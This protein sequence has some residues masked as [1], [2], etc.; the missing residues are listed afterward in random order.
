MTH[1]D[2]D[3]SQVLSETHDVFNQLHPLENQNLFTQDTALQEAV[4]RNGAAWA[5]EQ[6]SA[7]GLLTGSSKVIEWGFLA[8]KHK[9]SFKTHDRFGRR[10]DQV[11]FHPSYHHLM[12]QAIE[13]GLHASP[14]TDPKAGAHVARAA[15]TYMQSQVEAGHGCPI[16]MT[17]ACTPTFLKQPNVAKE[18]LPK[19]HASTYDPS[20]KPY[21]EKSGLTIGMGMT[22]KQ[23]GSDVRANTTRAIPVGQPGPGELY[24]LIGHKWFLSA[25]MCDGFLVLAQAEGGLSCFLVPRWQPDGTRNPMYVQQLK[26][27][28][29]NVSNASSEVE[30][31]GAIAWLIGEEGRGVANILEMVALTRFD[32]MVGSSAGMRQAVSQI[33]HHAQHRSVFGN[34]L[35]EQPLMQNVLADLALESEAAMSLSFRMAKALDNMANDEHEALLLRIGTAVGKYWICKR[36]PAHAYEAMECIGG[37]AVMEDCIMPRLYREAPINAIWE[38]SGNV[39][40]LDVLRAI[41]KSPKTLDALMSELHSAQGKNSDYD[42]ALKQAST[43]M[44]D[45]NSFESQGR[46]IVE[47]LATL[48]QGSILINAGNEM[49]SDLF[50]AARLRSDTGNMFG[51]IPSTENT[52]KFNLKDYILRATL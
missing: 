39:Q 5:N 30:F 35:I 24:Q 36:T 22:E 37:A 4:E 3:N 1:Q 50:C 29:G 18:W 43:F 44:K 48:L 10:V 8:N 41:N 27:K 47:K 51:T 14:W 13:N 2:K 32:C 31:R 26:D 46:I 11:D 9:P 19:I 6:L 20:N 42:A 34:T 23:G 15:K 21:F 38:G 16:T 45:L 12:Q 52:N 33:I 7:F 28:M 17:F 25:P 40:C 49:V